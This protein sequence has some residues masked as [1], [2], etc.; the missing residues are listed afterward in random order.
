MR[1]CAGQKWKSAIVSSRSFHFLSTSNRMPSYCHYRLPAQDNIYIELI[2]FFS[3]PIFN[4]WCENEFRAYFVVVDQSIRHTVIRRTHKSM[5]RI[6]GDEF[7]PIKRWRFSDGR[8]K[9]NGWQMLAIS[10]FS[11]AFTQ[12]DCCDWWAVDWSELVADV[13]ISR[14]KYITWDSLLKS[15]I[16]FRQILVRTANATL[17]VTV[18]TID[19]VCFT[20]FWFS[21]W[22]HRFF[23]WRCLAN[24]HIV[25]HFACNIEIFPR[26]FTS[27]CVFSW[28]MDTCTV[29]RASRSQ[30]TSSPLNTRCEQLHKHICSA[31]H[32]RIPPYVHSNAN[33]ILS[34]RVSVWQY[35]FFPDATSESR[36]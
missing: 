4:L 1:S 19:F 31:L 7:H 5:C 25:I 16:Y 6:S 15:I 10:M 3:R 17:V 29:L 22:I 8:V 33:V 20:A 12:T 30:F 9:Q 28:I 23:L 11:F 21:N 2:T 26:D 36:I 18:E 34:L 24:L 32:T 35:Y 27:N 13:T 14:E